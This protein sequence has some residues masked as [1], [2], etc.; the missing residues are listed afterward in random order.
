MFQLNNKLTKKVEFKKKITMH[1]K[2]KETETAGSISGLFYKGIVLLLLLV[3]K[4]KSITFT[5]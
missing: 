5:V 4:N 3:Y 1:H 2:F